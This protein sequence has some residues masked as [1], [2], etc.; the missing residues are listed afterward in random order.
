MKFATAWEHWSGLE[1]FLNEIINS[2]KVNYILKL[3]EQLKQK[4]KSLG[5]NIQVDQQIYQ[6][7]NCLLKLYY[8]LIAFA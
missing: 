8:N 7:L 2:Y 1:H 4:H 5:S 3:L 6:A